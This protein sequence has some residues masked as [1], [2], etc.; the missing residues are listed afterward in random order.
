MT[1]RKGSGRKKKEALEGRS[2]R[3]RRRRMKRFDFCSAPL[4][5]GLLYSAGLV[6]KTGTKAKGRKM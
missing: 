5:N 6:R 3:R 4:I 2:R 1:Q